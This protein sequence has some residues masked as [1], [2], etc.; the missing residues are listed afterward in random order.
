ME[1]K[2]NTK[3]VIGDI[4]P[5]IYGHFIEH[6]HKQV[7]G[8]VY[9]PTSKFA[10]EDGFRTDVLDALRQI[11]VPILRWPGG[12]FVDDY[13]WK[14]GVG[15]NRIPSFDKNWRVEEPNTF[16]TD[17]FMKL[18]KKIGCEP[19][20]CTNAGTAPPEE[21]S[22]WVEYCNLENE[23]EFA[24]QRIANGNVEPYNVKYWSIGN[25]N[26]YTMQ[27]GNKSISDW[28]KFT[29]NSAKM[30][31]RVTPT[32]ELSVSGTAEDLDWTYKVL[33]ECKHYLKW[34][35]LHGYWDL[36]FHGEWGKSDPL[37]GV[38]KA[39]RGIIPFGSKDG[40]NANY[41]TVMG[42]TSAISDKIDRMRGLLVAMS[43][44]KQVKISFDEWN[45]RGWY[46][47][48]VTNGITKEDYVTP[49]DKNGDNSTYTMADAVFTACFLNTCCRNCDIVGMANFSPVVNTRGAIFTHKNGIVKRS[50]YHVFDLY[51]NKMGDKT[52]DIWT[53]EPEK[54][55]VDGKE[56][57]TLDI[58]AALRTKDNVLTV[59]VVNKHATETQS[60]QFNFDEIVPKNYKVFSIIGKDKDSYNDIDRNEIGIELSIPEKQYEES[61]AFKFSP[62]SVNIVEFYL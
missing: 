10:D 33:D 25:E 24:K 4:N 7:Y 52:I 3:R 43:L 39:V 61:E 2:I 38:P 47:P 22:D 27:I 6:F 18:C 15:P 21:S 45:L 51:V 55:H 16:G 12:C 44:D 23:G 31:T 35:S 11:Q 20:F 49:R 17:E 9:D 59:A 5:M 56:V 29:K 13:H 54:Y 42:R 26:Y 14:K 41:E 46:H 1:Y 37:D 36:V 19:F 30:M 34:V 60:I 8:G 53:S 28:I 58:V 50:T 48:N 32:L 62:H 57:N 40:K